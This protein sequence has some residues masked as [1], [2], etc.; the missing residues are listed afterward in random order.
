M[1]LT[2]GKKEEKEGMAASKEDEMI[3]DFISVYTAEAWH[4]IVAA[5]ARQKKAIEKARSQENTVHPVEVTAIAMETVK[6]T[7]LGGT[8]TV[9]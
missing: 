6:Q 7:H 3:A 9:T 4:S 1:G 8:G 2:D 5:R